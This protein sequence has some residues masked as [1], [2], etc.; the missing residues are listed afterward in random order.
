MRVSSAIGFPAA[1]QFI[2]WIIRNT[3][4]TAEAVNVRSPRMTYMRIRMVAGE[5]LAGCGKTYFFMENLSHP[6]I[7]LAS[8]LFDSHLADSLARSAFGSASV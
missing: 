2:R 1:L 8:F 7:K 4:G 3:I 6:A 5:R